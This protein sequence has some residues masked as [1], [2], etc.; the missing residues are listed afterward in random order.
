MR[1]GKT[2][3]LPRQGLDPRL[4]EL[5]SRADRLTPDELK[6]LGQAMVRFV[7]RTVGNCADHINMPPRRKP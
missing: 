2:C 4:E 7:R 5:A 6:E 3:E 1:N